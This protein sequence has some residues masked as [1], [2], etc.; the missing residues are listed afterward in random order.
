[1]EREKNT[2]KSMHEHPVRPPTQHQRHRRLIRNPSTGQNKTST[3]D[4]NSLESILVAH[5]IQT[6]ISAVESGSDVL[7]LAFE[8]VGALA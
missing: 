2:P 6:D 5:P 1:M 3:T 8:G 7:K 4:K